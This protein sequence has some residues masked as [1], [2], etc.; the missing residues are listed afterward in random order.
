M[1]PGDSPDFNTFRAD[2]SNMQNPRNSVLDRCLY[3]ATSKLHR[4]WAYAYNDNPQGSIFQPPFTPT[5][6][7]YSIMLSPAQLKPDQT[8]CTDSVIGVRTHEVPLMTGS[9]Q[10]DDVLSWVLGA[11]MPLYVNPGSSAWFPSW[12]C[13]IQAHPGVVTPLVN[14]NFAA[15]LKHELE[16]G[17]DLVSKWE[18]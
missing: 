7:G 8:G 14:N 2:V 15:S 6:T 11:H 9:S 17:P 13:L 12:V 16:H 3:K 10:L 18:L 1:N 4:N 5:N